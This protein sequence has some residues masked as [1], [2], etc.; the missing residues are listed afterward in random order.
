M[1]LIPAIDILNKQVVRLRQ[2]DF[3]QVQVYS[4][5]PVATAVDFAHSGVKHLHLVD[6]SGAQQQR[7]LSLDIFARIKQATSCSIE[8]GGGIRSLGDA[9][10]FFARLD[11]KTDKIMIGSLPFTDADEFF[12]IVQKY[13]ASILLTVDV[14]GEEIRIKGWQEKSSVNLFEFLQNMLSLG[15]ENFLVTQIRLDGMLSGPDIKLYRK[16]L[17][18]FPKIKLTAS[19]GVSDMQDFTELSQLKN[20]Q[21]AI[22]GKAFYEG[23]VSLADI[24]NFL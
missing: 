6:L 20:I 21:G 3:Q 16:I 7:S 5:D 23:K 12:K 19:G 4:N 10:N 17:Q 22:L 14:W 11:T 8:A 18:K 2:G 1:L 13:A 15:I 9:E 24:K